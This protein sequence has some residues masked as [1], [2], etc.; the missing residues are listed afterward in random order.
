MSE[1]TAELV[2]TRDGASF[3]DNRYS[4]RHR[5]SFDG[6]VSVTASSSPSVAPLPYS[7]AAGVDPE[8]LFVAALASC[9]LLWFLS[10]ALKH[11]YCVERYEDHAHGMLGRNGAG[12]LAVTLVVL[13]PKVTFA[14][15]AQP[16]RQELERMHHLAHEE[17][18]IASAVLAEVRC[19]PVHEE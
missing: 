16:S 18:F 3:T 9:H 2:W 10:V 15:A 1:H 12:K 13:R 19:E 11:G 14:G 5:L 4:R 8:E 17:C 6:G 7:D